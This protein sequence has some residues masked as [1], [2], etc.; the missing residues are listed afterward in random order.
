[1]TVNP[2]EGNDLYEFGPFRL[3]LR[4]RLLS[5]DSEPLPLA[6]KCFDVL[7]HL[8]RNAGRAVSR[9]E[10]LAAVWPDVVVS[11]GSLTQAVFVLRR[12]LDE[13]ED[14]PGFLATVPRVGYRFSG[15]V[16]AVPGPDVPQAVLPIP[17]AV[18]A[19]VA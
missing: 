18:P 3:D 1:M 13:R 9:E 14:A 11:D 8:A 4:A 15:D 10:L 12:A 17:A 7:S 19:A 16:R 2:L 5:R 6:P